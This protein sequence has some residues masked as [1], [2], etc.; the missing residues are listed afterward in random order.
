[1]W[2]HFFGIDR[3]IN[4]TGDFRAREQYGLIPRPQYAYGMLRAADQAKYIGAKSVTVVELGVASGRGL[5][6]MIDCAKLIT[7]ETGITFRVIGFDTGAGLPSIEGYK[8]H[9]EIWNPGDFAMEDRVTLEKRLEGN[10]QIV[11]GDIDRTIDTFTKSL[12]PQA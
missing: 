11:W 10:A 6:N 12:T 7:A 8:D 2:S 9:P 5:L 3:W 1:I 4:R